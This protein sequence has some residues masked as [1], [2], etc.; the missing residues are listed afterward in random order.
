NTR[1]SE[2]QHHILPGRHHGCWQP[3]KTTSCMGLVFPS[4]ICKHSMVLESLYVSTSLRQKLIGKELGFIRL[5]CQWFS[6]RIGLLACFKKEVRK[7]RPH[8]QGLNTPLWSALCILLAQ[9]LLAL[10]DQVW[11]IKCS[12]WNSF[13][14]ELG[15]SI[16]MLDSR[17]ISLRGGSQ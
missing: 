7:G 4:R 5:L 2:H 6:V 17:G 1:E 8:L 16:R 10:D 9:I 3:S 13:H 12:S 15:C 11:I 14:Q